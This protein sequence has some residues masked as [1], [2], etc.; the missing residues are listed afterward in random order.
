[1]ASLRDASKSSLSLIISAACI[2]AM[3][4]ISSSSLLSAA[5]CMS[6]LSSASST[7]WASSSARMSSDLGP[8]TVFMSCKRLCSRSFD[9]ELEKGSPSPFPNVLRSTPAVTGPIGTC[10]GLAPTPMPS[11]LAFMPISRSCSR[12][13]EDVFI[14]GWTDDDGPRIC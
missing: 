3:F 11:P 9:E 1:M 10:P 14:G 5:S 7:R 2:L 4:T 6:R 8:T 12:A 13:F